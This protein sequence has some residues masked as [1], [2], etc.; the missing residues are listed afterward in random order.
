MTMIAVKGMK[1][2]GIVLLNKRNFRSD[3]ITYNY[4]SLFDL[5]IKYLKTFMQV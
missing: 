2:E 5:L 1:D 3:I 4:I